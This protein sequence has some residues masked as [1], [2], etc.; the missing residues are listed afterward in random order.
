[1]ESS[2]DFRLIE[3]DDDSTIDIEDGHTHLTRT[4]DHLVR[5]SR[6]LGDIVLGEG[7]SF[8]PQPIFGYST[9][10]TARRGIDRDS[11]FISKAMVYAK[12][13]ILPFVS[14]ALKR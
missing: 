5:L 4:M 3:A 10:A 7:N 2:L 6:I 14:Q 12:N 8:L 13:N 9:I 11:H 1:M